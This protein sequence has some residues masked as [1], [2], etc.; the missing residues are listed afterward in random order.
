MN[1]YSITIAVRDESM[2]AQVVSNLGSLPYNVLIGK[3]YPSFSKLVNTVIVNSKEEIVIFCSHRVRPTPTDIEKI[4]NLLEQ[5]YGLVALYKFAFFGLRKELIRRVGFMDERF[6]GGE[7]EDN[8]F[9]L[10]L[11]EANIAYYESDKVTYFPGGSTWN[12]QLTRAIFYS[13]WL[14]RGNIITRLK[15]ELK[16]DYDLG[17]SDENII[18][19]PWNKSVSDTIGY[20]IS[21]EHLNHSI[22][23]ITQTNDSIVP[24]HLRN[25]PPPMET[26]DHASI[27]QLFAKWI[28]PNLYVEFGVREGPVLVTVAPFCKKVHGIDIN[29]INSGICNKFNQ[30]T[31]FQMTT[32]NYVD[33]LNKIDPKLIIDMAFIDAHHESTKVFKDFEGLFPYVI[34]DGFIFLHN[35]Y[36]YDKCMT[37]PILCNDCYKVPDMIKNKYQDVCEIVTLP[38]NPGLTIVKKK[39][40]KL[41]AF[42][43]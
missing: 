19:L 39:I 16:Y 37:S 18:F 23:N 3:D 21:R 29:P 24:I 22:E 11:N 35:T 17:S 31:P 30:L 14:K 6:I 8:D 20:S 1:N 41:P 7:H 28:K 40:Q 25:V 43:N 12:N 10:R 15:N 5:G 9:V 27:L 33:L 26:F 2:V 4:I 32:D 13:K 36:P 42:M 34:E 38:F